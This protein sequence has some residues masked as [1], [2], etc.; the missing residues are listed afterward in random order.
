M[1]RSAISVVLLFLATGVH[2]V[3]YIEAPP[4][5]PVSAAAEPPFD[6]MDESR[7]E[8]GKVSFN[9]YCNMFCHGNEGSGGKT[10]AFKGRKDFM[11]ETLFKKIAE[12]TVPT[13]PPYGRN[14]PEE[15]RW[16]LIAYILFLGR[17]SVSQ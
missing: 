12:G 10:P 9:A 2:A 8:A 4:A 16:E 5:A 15:K 13:M 3:G 1:I 17:Q 6:L 7:I 14:L 11:P